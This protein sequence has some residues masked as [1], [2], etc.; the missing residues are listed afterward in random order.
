MKKLVMPNLEEKHK[1]I[2]YICVGFILLLYTLNFFAR[3][4]SGFF[5][6]FSLALMLYGAYRTELINI[7]F[8]QKK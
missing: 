4:L 3:W 2:I 7:H 1:G 8:N 5:F 6:I